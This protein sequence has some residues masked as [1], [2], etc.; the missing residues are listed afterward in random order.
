VAFPALR[1]VVSWLL[2]ASPREGGGLV[3]FVG[4]C[5]SGEGRKRLFCDPNMTTI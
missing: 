1:G 2:L 5:R 4:A 3:V